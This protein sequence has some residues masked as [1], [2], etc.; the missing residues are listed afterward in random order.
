MARGWR[1]LERRSVIVSL[2]GG[3]QALEGILWATSGDLLLLRHAQML[4][5]GRDARPMDGEVAVE[6][7]RIEFVQV[8]SNG[9]GHLP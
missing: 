6:R 5:P 1:S 3:Q 9:N 7:T 8:L 2:I 4:E